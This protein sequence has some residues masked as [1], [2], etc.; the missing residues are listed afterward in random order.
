MPRAD[1]VDLSIDPATGA[2]VKAVIDPGEDYETTY[3]IL[4]YAEPIPGKKVIGSFRIGDAGG[5][6]TYTRIEPNIV[7][8]DG[9]L[10]PQPRPRHRL[11]ELKAVSD[12]LTP[13]YHRPRDRR[14]HERN[15][16]S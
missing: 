6:F 10:H 5:K 2:I 9:E 16:C 1:A 14:R 3:H 11:R 12:P 15:V 13:S 8:S 7:I 4:S